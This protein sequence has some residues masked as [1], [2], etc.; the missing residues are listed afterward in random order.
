M[1]IY[2]SILP[3]LPLPTS[4]PPSRYLPTRP[5]PPASPHRPLPTAP[6]AARPLPRHPTCCPPTAPPAT[7]PLPR[8][9]ARRPARYPARLPARHPFL[10]H[11]P[12][13][14]STAPPPRCPPPRPTVV[15]RRVVVALL[16]VGA[17]ARR[18]ATHCRASRHRVCVGGSR[19]GRGFPPWRLRVVC[20]ARRVAVAL[21]KRGGTGASPHA[22]R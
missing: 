7:H 9:P 10:R 18:G 8:L 20:A 3:R 12:P 5:P 22:L 17:C 14:H 2:S 15:A 13:C 6:P 19:R 16:C 1:S 11:L 4:C 21:R